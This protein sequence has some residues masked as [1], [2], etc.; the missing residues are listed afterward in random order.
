MG[1]ITDVETAEYFMQELQE[2]SGNRIQ[3]GTI[4]KFTNEPSTSKSATNDFDEFKS[5]Y[6]F[7]KSKDKR[8]I[9]PPFSQVRYIA[10]KHGKD[11]T[12]TKGLSYTEYILTDN[13]N[14]R[15]CVRD[16]DDPVPLRFEPNRSI[17]SD[18]KL[19]RE[20]SELE[21]KI[22]N[23]SEVSLWDRYVEQVNKEEEE[24][25]AKQKASKLKVKW[26]L[27]KMHWTFDDDRYMK[28]AKQLEKMLNLRE[29]YFTTDSQNIDLKVSDVIAK[30]KR[31]VAEFKEV[32]EHALKTLKDDIAEMTEKQLK[33]QQRLEE[34]EAI[35]LAN[36][37]KLKQHLTGAEKICEEYK[38]SL[39]AVQGKD[40][41]VPI[42]DL[43]RTRPDVTSFF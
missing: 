6:D 20:R 25:Q 1:D 11:M 23:Q 12:G 7:M 14:Q 10:Q 13:Q 35:H 2:G 17:A 31:V 34:I 8:D 29:E 40:L 27:L 36:K 28:L 19:I 33:T 41:N 5:T 16:Y 39:S 22:E 26:I 42:S 24:K 18:L 38:A 9:L 4:Y 15:Y 37:D 21:R 32:K 3:F 30:S 43:E